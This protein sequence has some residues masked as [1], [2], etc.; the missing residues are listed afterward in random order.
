MAGDHIVKSYDVA[1]QNLASLLT[2]MGGLA[3]AQ[4][5][6][7]V[8]AILRRDTD[9]AAEVIQGDAAIDQAEREVDA[10]V[11]RLL[12]L[13]QPMG[14]DLRAVVGSLKIASDLERIGDYAANI[15]KRAIALSHVAPQRS[16]AAVDRIGHLCQELLKDVL[17]A[18][19]ERDVDKAISVW[20]RDEELDELYT[21][22]FREVLTYMM[23]DPRSITPSTHLLFVAKN[24]E[25]IGDHA[26]NIAETIHFLVTGRPMTHLRPKHDD[27]SFDAGPAETDPEPAA[28][29]P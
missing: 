24:L 17:D 18:F 20:N 11:V 29:L 9:L 21:S 26:T 8:Q 2:R 27:S 16:V 28:V 13:R 6:S 5:A 10:E 7:A 14:I 25:R 12:A 15:G 19:I 3:E 22:L 1:L 4:I 23:E